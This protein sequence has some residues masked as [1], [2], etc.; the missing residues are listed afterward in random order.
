MSPPPITHVATTDIKDMMD[1][2]SA[3]RMDLP[4]FAEEFVDFPHYII[5]ITE[6]IWHDKEIELCRDWYGE[7][8]AIHTLAGNV[9]GVQTVIDNTHATLKAFPDR[10]LD[11]DNVIWSEDEHGT[12]HSSHLITSKMTNEGPSEFGPAT[13]KKVRVTTIADCLCKDNKIIE[14]WLVRDN[15]AITNQLGFD[16]NTVAAK[17]VE[18]DQ[19]NNFNII[20]FHAENRKKVSGIRVDDFEG[21]THFAAE[22][23]EI[24]WNKKQFSKL[25]DF[26]DFR[27]DGIYPGGEFLYGH[28]QVEAYIKP[29][30]DSLPDAQISIDHV[31]EIPYLGNAKDVAIRWSLK[32]NHTGEGRYGKPSGAPIYILGVSQFRIMNGKIRE[33]RV[34]WDDIAV[35]RQI[36]AHIQENT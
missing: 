33:E 36:Q 27:V 28:D 14:E 20:K 18:V 7:D 24:I 6:R 15:L 16:A 19:R 31:A 12:F 10:R 22:M 2:G 5:R 1:A 3:R 34:V 25:P 8:C 11:A 9:A 13:G 35:R 29:L 4:G 21:A 30:F 17:Q 26:Y 23:L 32:A